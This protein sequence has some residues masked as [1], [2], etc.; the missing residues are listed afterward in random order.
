MTYSEPN[1]SILV[2]DYMKPIESRLCLQSIKEY[3]KIPHQVIFCDNGS[4][5]DY[6]M[7]FVRDGLVD[8]LIVNR[9]SRG[10]G[11]GTRDLY[12]LTHSYWTIYL[13]NDQLFER[14]LTETEFYQ[15]GS[16]M[17]GRDSR[18]KTVA[19]ISLAGAPCG[20][21][22]YSE[23]AHLIRTSD[24]KLWEDR[25]PLGHYGAGPY[26][27][28]PWREERMQS[29]Y[30]SSSLTHLAWPQ[31]LVQDNG[32]YAIRG[33]NDKEGGLWLHR[34]DNK[35]LWCII[36][37]TRCNPAYPKFTDEERNIA[38][39][40]EWPDGAIPELELPHSF[41]CWDHTVLGQ[42]QEGYIKDL[43]RRAAARTTL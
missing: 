9:D 16:W 18:G 8:Q 21:G 42:M 32:V 3:V 19:S 33:M 30:R 22:E 40:G 27:N 36:P 28:G 26:H 5:E 34:T 43:R 29:H 15:I 41:S 4:G 25:I 7:Q 11:L 2:L 39:R 17:G 38:E 20:V 35:R 12:S 31:P 37:P 1:L 10:L 23:R 6:P 14:D 24:Y 13:Q